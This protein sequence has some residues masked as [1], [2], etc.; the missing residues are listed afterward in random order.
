MS[1]FTLNFRDN[2]GDFL[3]FLKQLYLGAP[4]EEA[5]RAV[6][7]LPAPHVQIEPLN[8]KGRDKLSRAIREL[9]AAERGIDPNIPQGCTIAAAIHDA[10]N[11][12]ADSLNDVAFDVLERSGELG[13][14]A[15]KEL[16]VIQTALLN[17]TKIV[18]A[19]KLN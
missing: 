18:T 2:D 14:A 8:F 6:G 13:E 5:A 19:T 16:E 3:N 7:A 15:F 17:F 1:T 10:S 12:V 9:G 11:A 4:V